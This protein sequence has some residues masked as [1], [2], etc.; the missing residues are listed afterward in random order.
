MNETARNEGPSVADQVANPD[1]TIISIPLSFVGPARRRQINAIASW[2]NLG[3]RVAVVLY[4]REDGVSEVSHEVGAVNVADVRTNLNGTPLVNDV[5]A[6]AASHLSSRF[7]MFANSDMMFCQDLLASLDLIALDRFLVVG[8]RINIDIEEDLD[9]S[10][11]DTASRMRER[12][13]RDGIMQPP[14][15]SDYFIFPRMIHWQMP[16][17]AVGRLGWDNWMMFRARQMHVPLVDAT[18]SITAV[19]QNHNYGHVRSRKPGEGVV[20]GVEDSANWALA[21]GVEAIFT[22]WD[23]D[24]VLADGVLVRPSGFK[25]TRRRLQSALVLNP[26]TRPVY[27]AVR[28][29]WAA[30][31]TLLR[32]LGWISPGNEAIDRRR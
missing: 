14:V 22:L 8:N 1:L 32:T 28:N 19:H 18:K 21:G 20:P 27:T 2:K 4:G 31:R 29:R 11:S 30:I 25:Y 13:L 12:A 6:H 15:G 10:T 7:L 5:M 24:Y 16:D 17:L 9:F 3:P 26:A 23:V